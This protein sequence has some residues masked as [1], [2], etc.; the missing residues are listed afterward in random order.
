MNVEIVKDILYLSK[1]RIL[2]M[3][4]LLSIKSSGRARAHGRK[5]NGIKR[6]TRPK[7]P[8]SVMQHRDIFWVLT[9]F[10]DSCRLWTNMR[11][12]PLEMLSYYLSTG[13]QNVQ[14]GAHIR[15]GY[16]L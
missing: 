13:K 7:K 2:K 11:M 1:T 3:W 12:I 8:K 14:N 6:D 15:H 4:H 9:C 10:D 16:P 5:P